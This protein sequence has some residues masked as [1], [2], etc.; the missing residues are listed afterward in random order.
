MYPA[1]NPQSYPVTNPQSYIA[2]AQGGNYGFCP[3]REV[4]CFRYSIVGLSANMCSNNPL[5]HKEQDRL[6]YASFPQNRDTRMNNDIIVT[7]YVI[8]T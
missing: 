2:E 4:I 5:S 6:Q 7:I 8:G 1:T 3:L